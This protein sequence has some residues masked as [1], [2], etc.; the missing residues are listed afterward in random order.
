MNVLVVTVQVP[1]VR[2]GA[3]AMA[4]GL[5][6]ALLA[7]GHRA[8][9]VALPFKGYPAER[10]PEQ[11]L[12]CRLL[13]LSESNGEPVDRV[14]GLKF[15]AY[16][17]R[18]PRKVVWLVHQHRQAYELWGGPYGDLDHYA[19]G[20]AVR[21]AIRGADT[22]L[23]AEAQAVYAISA[24]VSRRLW[25]YNGVPSSPLYQPP[26]HAEAFWCAPADDYLFF[27]SR[28]TPHKRQDLVLHALR[29][30]RR[31]VRVRFAGS[32]DVAAEEGRLRRL[33][34]QLGVE[35]RVGWL[36]ALGEADKR[37]QYA[38]ARGVVF[39]PYEEDLG[40]VTLEAMLASKPVLT[41]RDS[42]GPL[43]FVVHEETGLVAEPTPEGLAGAMDRLWADPGEAAAW[44]R[45]GRRRY[46]G[47]EITWPRVVRRL[48]A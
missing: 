16:L 10:I 8:E 35:D 31:P 29:H 1:F 33:A 45:N 5:R 24:L 48:L 41:C 37:D 2:G 3:E 42:G 47:L 36:G 27:P 28:L 30:T 9:L 17:V 18:H 7:E 25:E 34:Q 44:G 46:E 4:E 11:M 26:P 12:A 43:E 13:D 39:P 38:R 15:P 22:L 21:D 14:I 23:G 32:A 20:P 19:D 40:L 6:Q